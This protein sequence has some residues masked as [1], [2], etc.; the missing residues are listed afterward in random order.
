[1]LCRIS[2]H[3]KVEILHL[4]GIE[5]FSF[6]R[7]CLN[8]NASHCS[9]KPEIEQVFLKL[10]GRQSVSPIELLIIDICFVRKQNIVCGYLIRLL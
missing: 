5:S 7:W 9:S 1:M 6:G 4:T 3:Y 8:L 2:L 10:F